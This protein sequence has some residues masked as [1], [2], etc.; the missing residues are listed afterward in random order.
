MIK[1]YISEDVRLKIMQALKEA[2][3]GKEWIFVDMDG[4]V[5][6]FESKATIEAAKMQLTFQQ[7]A[8][9]KQYRYIDGFYRDLPL[10]PGAKEAI[11][12][13]DACGKYEINFLS[14]PSWGNESCF[15]D[16]R[17]WT[18]ENFGARFEKRMDLSFHK[19]HYLGH[20]LIDD[21]TKYGA[22][23]FI[24]EHLQFGNSEYPNWDS[25]LKKL[26]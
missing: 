20:Y 19:G 15:T 13:L 8:E 14:A 22:G 12:E 6:D 9:Q 25:I 4:V 11:L 18:N 10:I 3:S 1:K 17:I 23:D 26:L 5:A 16:K 7:F 24:G 21:R 2:Y